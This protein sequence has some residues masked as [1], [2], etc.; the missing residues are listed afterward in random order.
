MASIEDFL[1][2]DIRVGRVLSADD[3]PTARKPMYVLKVGFGDAGERQ[4]VAGIKEGYVKEEIVGKLVIGIVNLDH[5]TVAGIVSE[6]MLLAAG[7]AEISMLTA[8]REVPEGSR[9]R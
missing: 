7:D 8:D 3:H 5:K 1:K 9:V 6:G 4:V 2:L